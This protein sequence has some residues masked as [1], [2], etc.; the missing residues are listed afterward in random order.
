V[1]T[2][3]PWHG[4]WTWGSISSC[5][6]VCSHPRDLGRPFVR[7]VGVDPR[8]GVLACRTAGRV[9]DRRGELTGT[10]GVD[11]GRPHENDLRP[12]GMNYLPL[13]APD[14]AALEH[15]VHRC[16]SSWEA[17]REGGC[18]YR[19]GRAALTAPPSGARLEGARRVL[20]GDY[21]NRN[22]DPAL[23]RRRSLHSH[24]APADERPW[25]PLWTLMGI[26]LGAKACRQ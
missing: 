13:H 1:A 16:A 23:P 3:W 14:A 7:V 26:T 8:A 17:C 15:A 19:T 10:A 25:I 5:S 6:N 18:A 21:G 11:A 24:A 20:A 4:N 2:R 9:P 12:V 22:I